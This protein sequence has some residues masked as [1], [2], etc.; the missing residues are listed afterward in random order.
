MKC[1]V[2]KDLM[3]VYISGLTSEETNAEIENHLENC[4]AC[5][6]I[7]AQMSAVIPDEVPPEEKDIDFL[8]KLRGTMRQRYLITSLSTCALLV[9]LIVFLKKFDTPVSY[10]PDRMTAEIFQIAYVPNESGL[11]Q[12][13]DLD[14]LDPKTASAVRLGKYD[15][16]EQVRLVLKDNVNSNGFASLGRTIQRNGETVRVV[17]YCYTKS[18]WNSM[19]SENGGFVDYS[20]AQG[21]V[22]EDDFFIN[23]NADY[24]PEKREIYYLPVENMNRLN[25]LSDEEFDAQ[26]ENA[27]LVWSGVN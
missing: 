7:Y 14:S 8:K 2:V 11:R 12:W 22:Y 4:N 5:S 1:C 27:D 10:D 23:A 19:F 16:Q 17:Y 24:Q 15:T 26:K 25:R 18:L 21:D 6:T 20:I 3:P 13:R 9:C